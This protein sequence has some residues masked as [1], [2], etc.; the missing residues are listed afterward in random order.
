MNQCK[1]CRS[2][3][4]NIGKRGRDDSDTDLC[5]VC[6]WRTRA[7]RLQSALLAAEER[8]ASAVREMHLYR[9]YATRKGAE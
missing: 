5:D 7:D 1:K 8:A 6:Y 2:Y 4:I 9:D 3:A